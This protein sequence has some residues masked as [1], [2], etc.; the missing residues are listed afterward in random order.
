[1]AT[2]V[3]RFIR[4]SPSR[5][6]KLAD[7]VRGKGVDEAEE[8]LRLMPQRGARYL[9]KLIHSAAANAENNDN[10]TREELFIS[11]L[12]VNEG[13]RLKRY[14]PRGRGRAD[15]LLKRTSHVT[16]EVQQLDYAETAKS[17]KA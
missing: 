5:L 15:R 6:R 16:V 8:L 9:R 4:V 12:V 10:L 1:M 7:L 2:A 14:W 13:P 11:Y 17:R 3:G